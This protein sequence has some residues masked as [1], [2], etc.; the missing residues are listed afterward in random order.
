MKLQT[1]HTV[2]YLLFINVSTTQLRS[3]TAFS[4]EY[5]GDSVVNKRRV[6]GGV[7][8]CVCVRACVCVC[9]CVHACVYVCACVCAC[10]NDLMTNTLSH[11]S[12]PLLRI[13]QYTEY[14]TR[15]CC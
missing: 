11:V 7:C 14:V 1:P 10:V 2:L 15:G 12:Q 9:V 4:S 3:V 5:R 8:V 13:L 6:T